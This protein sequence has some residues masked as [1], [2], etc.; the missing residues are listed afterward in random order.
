MN[1]YQ[2]STLAAVAALG[3]SMSA[4]A[5]VT[6]YTDRTSWLAAAGTPSFTED[7]ESF[8]SDTSYA[9][10]PLVLPNFT[11]STVGSAPAG[12]NFVDV[13]PFTFS[14]IPASFGNAHLESYVEGPLTTSLTFVAPVSAFF[15]D[16]LWAGNSSQLSMALKLS[17]GST[18]TVLVPGPGTD[19]VPFGFVSAGA[20]VTGITFSNAA[21]DGFAIDNIAGVSAVPEPE[22]YAM[23]VAGLAMI[24]AI[25][26]RRFAA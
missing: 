8:A 26:R 10:A 6:T 19:L 17:D 2:L 24:G 16:F 12:T 9:T 3:F 13:Y 18:E 14:G 23:L 1:R 5:A 21:N 7:F 20:K 4:A 15:A 11:V 25:A 22:S